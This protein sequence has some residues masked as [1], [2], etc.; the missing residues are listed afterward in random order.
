MPLVSHRTA[1]SADGEDTSS[2]WN[3]R[4]NTWTQSFCAAKRA[5]FSGIALLFIELQSREMQ[6]T[7]HTITQSVHVH[8]HALQQPAMACMLKF[9]PSDSRP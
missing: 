6:A 1:V 4:E 9:M 5:A 7:T 3:T 8:P 2:D